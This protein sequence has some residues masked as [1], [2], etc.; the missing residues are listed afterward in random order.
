MTTIQI[1]SGICGFLTVVRALRGR[2]KKV[3]FSIQSDCEQ[4]RALGD[5]LSE[6]DMRGIIMMPIHHNPV[7]EAAGK[8]RLHASCPVPCGVIKAAEVESGL[9][10]RRD[11]KITFQNEM[12]AVGDGG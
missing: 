3:G 5:E 12:E 1:Q 6:L 2:Q 10:I 4:V 11:V 8:C 9:A 7:Y